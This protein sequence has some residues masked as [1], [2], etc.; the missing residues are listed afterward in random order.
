[1]GVMRR[2]FPHEIKSYKSVMFF[3]LTARQI[4]CIVCALALAI[5][6][7]FICSKLNVDID[8]IGYIII[9][10][11]V[12]FGAVGWCT[13]NDMAMEV[14]VQTILKFYFCTRRRKWQFENTETKIHNAEMNIELEELTAARKKEI[15]DEKAKA[16][17]E[18][19][20]EKQKKRENKKSSKKG[21]VKEI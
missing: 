11:V 16:K 18:K 14:F 1:M 5:P 8:T 13:Y 19:K 6:T 10:E 17:E 9:L 4:L 20:I 15:A 7:G 21:K 2:K 3:G 12:P